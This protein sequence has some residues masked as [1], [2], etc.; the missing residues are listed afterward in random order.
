MK[1]YVIEAI[2]REKLHIYVDAYQ[3]TASPLYV[4]E[5][6]GADADPALYD[7][8]AAACGM[9]VMRYADGSQFLRAR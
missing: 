4:L 1:T 7:K 9:R 8:A 3:I 2:I 6:D 5:I